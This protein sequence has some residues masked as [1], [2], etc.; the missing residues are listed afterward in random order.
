MAKVRET[1][2]KVHAG[3]LASGKA[4]VWIISQDIRH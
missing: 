3:T 4:S 1:E 2:A